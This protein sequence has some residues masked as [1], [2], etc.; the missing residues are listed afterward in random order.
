VGAHDLGVPCVR[1]DGVLAGTTCRLPGLRRAG[2]QTQQDIAERLG[3]SKTAVTGWKQGLLPRWELVKTAARVLATPSCCAL[4][5]W[6]FT[7][8][9]RA[10][11][12]IGQT[13]IG[14]TQVEKRRHLVSERRSS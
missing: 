3:V 5:L 6:C 10:P 9:V 11:R 7:D 14:P 13:W 12:V 2:D 4:R 8:Q 1:C